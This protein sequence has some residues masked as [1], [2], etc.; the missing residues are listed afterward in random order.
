[1]KFLFLDIDG[2][3]NS[4]VY[5][6][7]SEYLDECKAIGVDPVGFE[8]VS[9]A[10]FLHIDPAAVKLVNSLVDKSGVK[11]I[12]SSTWRTRYSIVEM[13]AMLAG[14]G[15]TFKI[16]A[17]TPAKMSR[18]PREHDIAAFLTN[19]KSQGITPEAFVIIDDINEFSKYTKQ[20][21]QTTEANGIT[22]ENVDQALNILGVESGKQ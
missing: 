12:L 10:H 6:A 16:E 7:S 20:F 2:V 9:K 22:Q 3:L 1:M 13:N 5:M 14:R 8:V 19:T 15:A 11:V 21:V 17:V 18:R 4:D